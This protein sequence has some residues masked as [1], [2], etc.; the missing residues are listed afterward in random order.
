VGSVGS[1]TVGRENSTTIELLYE[2]HGSGQLRTLLPTAEYVEMDGA[3]HGLLWTH[4]DE[5]NG[6]LMA[7][8]TK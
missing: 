2:D 7:F 6:L 1:V 8:I 5:V 3:P 4:G